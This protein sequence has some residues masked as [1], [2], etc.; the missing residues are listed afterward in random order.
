MPQITDPTDGM[1]SFQQALL[2]GEIDLQL[3]KLDPE[4]FVHSDS[5][6]PGVRRLT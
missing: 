2:D 5:A 4:I 3:V 1:V 6:T